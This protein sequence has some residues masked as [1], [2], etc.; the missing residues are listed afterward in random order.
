MIMERIKKFNGF[1]NES[2]SKIPKVPEFYSVSENG[3]VIINVNPRENVSVLD[4]DD[5]FVISIQVGD[6]KK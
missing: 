6:L 1:I 2:T 5:E 4:S 3:D